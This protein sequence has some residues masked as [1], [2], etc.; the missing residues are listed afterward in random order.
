MLAPTCIFI[1]LY[2][3]RFLPVTRRCAADRTKCIGCRTQHCVCASGIRPNYTVTLFMK[4]YWAYGHD[5]NIWS[6]VE[7]MYLSL[8]TRKYFLVHRDQHVSAPLINQSIFRVLCMKFTQWDGLSDLLSAY[9]IFKT[10]RG[11]RLK[12]EYRKMC[13]AYLTLFIS[14]R[15]FEIV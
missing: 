6:A 15:Y 1:K 8:S 9:F 12:F 10:T 13:R 4:I 11:I 7:G 5:M 14:V 3:R 2:Y